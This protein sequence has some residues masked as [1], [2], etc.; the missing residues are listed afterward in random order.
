MQRVAELAKQLY[1]PGFQ[2]QHHQT[3]ELKAHNPC[4]TSRTTF[5]QGPHGEG[6]GTLAGE[7]NT[8]SHVPFSTQAY[9]DPH[10][11]TGVVVAPGI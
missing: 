3:T 2:S 4:V 9:E 7:S 5:T 8:H 10:V 1:N 6:W 11:G